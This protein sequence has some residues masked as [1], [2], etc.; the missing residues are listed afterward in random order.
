MSQNTVNRPL[1]AA[2]QFAKALTNAINYANHIDEIAEYWQ[3][4]LLILSQV[5]NIPSGFLHSLMDNHSASGAQ[6]LIDSVVT[7][8]CCREVDETP[9]VA[10]K[11]ELSAATA[12]PRPF[13]GILAL[14]PRPEEMEC[15]RK[16]RNEIGVAIEAYA[17]ATEN[18]LADLLAAAFPTLQGT[19]VPDQVLQDKGLPSHEPEEW[20]FY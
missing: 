14:K 11:V 8:E 9:S 13:S 4:M 12:V 17:A 10:L 7:G 20:E 19:A 1:G 3:E 6:K 18:C 16:R 15:W 5:H 2:S